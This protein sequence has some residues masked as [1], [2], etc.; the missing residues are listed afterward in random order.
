LRFYSK[1]N[2]GGNLHKYWELYFDRAEHQRIQG[3]FVWDW[4]D[5]GEKTSR[6]Q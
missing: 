2:S 4:A 5:Q 1:G 6:V 3:G